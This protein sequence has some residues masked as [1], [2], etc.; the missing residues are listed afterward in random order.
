MI[1]LIL[2]IE[3]SFTSGIFKFLNSGL[4][5][6][7]NHLLLAKGPVALAGH[8]HLVGMRSGLFKASLNLSIITT[9]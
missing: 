9:Q 3:A 7:M 5:H 8:L 2:A 4:N 6:G 1:I